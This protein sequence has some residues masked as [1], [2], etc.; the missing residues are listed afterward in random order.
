MLFALRYSIKQFFRNPKRSLSVMSGII[1]SITL[2]SG[3]MIAADGLTTYKLYKGF[4]GIDFDFIVYNSQV[5]RDSIVDGIETVKNTVDSLGVI[6]NLYTS[7]TNTFWNSPYE[8]P[9]EN[10]NRGIQIAKMGEEMNSSKTEYKTYMLGVDDVLFNSPKLDEIFTFEM[11]NISELE[12]GQILIDNRTA[13]KKN[14]TIGDRF[15]LHSYYKEWNETLYDWIDYNFTVD[16]I[17]IVGT[18]EIWDHEKFNRVFQPNAIYQGGFL[19]T[20]Q[21]IPQV[22]AY[23]LG[24]FD[25]QTKVANNLTYY[26][27]TGFKEIIGNLYLIDLKRERLPLF[28][29]EV[30][31]RYLETLKNR[32][33]IESGDV[34]AWVYDELSGVY[35]S[36]Q[37]QLYQYELYSFFV[38]IPTILLGVLL[39]S[40]IFKLVLKQRRREFGQLKSH[41]A[42]S[43]QVSK[44]FYLEAVFVG[45]VGGLIGLII[46]VGISY[47]LIA[48]ILGEKFGEY[49]ILN[50]LRIDPISIMTSIA[51]AVILVFLTTYKPIKRYSE[52]NVVEIIP[53]FQEELAGG[54]KKGKREWIALI[55]GLIPIV[56]S[57]IQDLFG[58]SEIMY[59][60]SS[61][62]Q[63]IIPILTWIS[64][65]LLIYAVVKIISTRLVVKFTKLCEKFASMFSRKTSK[66]VATNITRNPVRAVHLI[67]IISTTICF[68]VIGQILTASQ[69]QH[70]FN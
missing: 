42:S 66:L 35:I 58:P 22:Y 44:I 57:F 12:Y 64:P 25:Y 8:Y 63:M 9:G 68:G 21:Y 3:I 33:I 7:Y 23:L 32:I 31:M 19:K 54:P 30:T 27:E 69:S 67:F 45:I 62:F 48:Q 16:E 2:L 61:L 55:L 29:A 11:I 18:F 53:H 49:L 38:S 36:V 60:W 34:N 59:L 28:N 65:F 10:L 50:P 43:R 37:A 6:D 1:I 4:E 5:D 20:Q 13:N 24:K 15:N 40:I 39:T 14:L 56:Y 17:T 52:M 47:G 51:I 26:F 46:S 41:G 70:E